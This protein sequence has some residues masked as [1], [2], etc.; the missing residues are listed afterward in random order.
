MK[1]NGQFYENGMPY[2]PIYDSI[3]EGFQQNT[4]FVENPNKYIDKEIWT[5]PYV[6]VV[7]IKEKDYEEIVKK[8][9]SLKVYKYVISPD[10]S[11]IWIVSK[12]YYI[13]A[14]N[15][16]GDIQKALP[17]GNVQCVIA[18]KSQPVCMPFILQKTA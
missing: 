18:S 13:R 3:V 5:K 16:S 11:E 9:G 2:L 7:S 15:I 4:N 1:H 17:K 10:F 12:D 6:L 8:F 14:K